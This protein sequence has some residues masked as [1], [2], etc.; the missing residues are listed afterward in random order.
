MFASTELYGIVSYHISKFASKET[1]TYTL[2]AI[3]SPALC[4]CLSSEGC[5]V[6]GCEPS[7]FSGIHLWKHED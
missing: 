3:S 6:V 1:L 4:E 5:I 2:V 7:T